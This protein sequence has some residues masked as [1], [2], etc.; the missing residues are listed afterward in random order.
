MSTMQY[1]YRP[2]RSDMLRSTKCKVT[3]YCTSVLKHG[4]HQNET[5][6]PKPRLNSFRGRRGIPR[7]NRIA[8]KETVV[9]KNLGN[10]ERGYKFRSIWHPSSARVQTFRLNC[11]CTRWCSTSKMHWPRCREGPQRSLC[12]YRLPKKQRDWTL[13]GGQQK[14]TQRNS[15]LKGW[16]PWCIAADVSIYVYLCHS[17][18]SKISRR[19]WTSPARLITG[20]LLVF[21]WFRATHRWPYRTRAPLGTGRSRQSMVW[22]GSR[23][24]CSSA[25]AFCNAGSA[26]CRPS[27]GKEKIQDECGIKPGAV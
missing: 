12:W 10:H 20:F 26:T 21:L 1:S 24:R 15:T 9:K 23:P 8:W 27:P 6:W 18:W 17:N 22:P 16:M 3:S 13:D 14:G 5:E 7:I 11:Q 19:A 2:H 4:K 25:G